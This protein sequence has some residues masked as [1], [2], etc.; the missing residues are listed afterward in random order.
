MRSERRT[1]WAWASGACSKSR[2]RR[3]SISARARP[4]SRVWRWSVARVA[5][6]APRASRTGLQRATRRQR[7]SRTASTSSSASRDARPCRPHSTGGPNAGSSRTS[8]TAA[9][10][11]CSS[12]S[13]PPPSTRSQPR[14]GSHV[15]KTSGESRAR[16][17]RATNAKRRWSGGLSPSG[18]HASASSSPAR[19]CAPRATGTYGGGAACPLAWRAAET[20]TATAR[21]LPRRRS[22]SPPQARHPGACSAGSRAPAPPCTAASRRPEGL[23]VT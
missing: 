23:R 7:R 18:R 14:I 10:I 6:T 2:T 21:W 12:A 1:R 4:S 9:S 20:T 22:S 5:A 8:T 19:R 3:A 11:V 13:S 16:A 17:S 15:A